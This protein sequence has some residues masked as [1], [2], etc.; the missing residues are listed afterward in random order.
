MKITPIL[1]PDN[2]EDL[3]IELINSATS[4]L[5]IEQES[6]VGYYHIDLGVEITDKIK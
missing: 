1:S 2:S 6:I 3:I 4:T 5:D